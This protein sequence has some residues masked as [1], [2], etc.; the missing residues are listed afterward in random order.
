MNPRKILSVAITLIAAAVAIVIGLALWHHYME[1]PWTR[2]GR[3]MADVV[4][5]TP[6]VSGL[7][8]DVPVKDNQFVKKGDRLVK[9][10]PSRYR[11]QVA[12]DKAQ[13][14]Q[15][16]VKL[17]QAQRELRRRQNLSDSVV[18]HEDLEIARSRV[19]SARSRLERA[20]AEL[21][22]ARLNL[23]RTEVKAPSDG[24][25]TNLRLYKGDYAKSGNPAMALVNSDTFRVN[26][27]FEENKLRRI[28]VGDPVTIR[29]L[30]SGPEFRG[31]VEGIARGVVD[32]DR[33]SS[34]DS[35]GRVNGHDMLA[36]VKPT[37][38]WVRLAQRVPVRIAI[39]AMPDD[40]DLAVGMTATVIVHPEKAD[41]KKGKERPS[42]ETLR[43]TMAPD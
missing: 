38:S 29:M 25:V 10:D 30:D 40:V 32:Q 36:H 23:K 14:S 35:P 7:A 22:L 4:A 39:D 6:D 31:H 5:V 42:L 8:V 37:Y 1:A 24:Y 15:A 28:H 2:D 34:G 16:R 20:Q 33:A 17:E 26:G 41:H 12:I 43:H 11:D 21:T 9:V 18:S 3:I 19:D 27:Y 13:V